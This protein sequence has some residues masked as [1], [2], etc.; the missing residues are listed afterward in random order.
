MR[1]V[2]MLFHYVW[3]HYTMAIADLVRNYLNLVDFLKNFFSIKHLIL[4][5]FAPWKKLSEEYPSGILNLGS[6]FFALIVNTLMRVVGFFIRLIFIIVG[7]VALL[8][9]LLLFILV[10]FIWILMPGILIFLLV[11]GYKLLMA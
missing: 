2:L 10:L 3:W 7:L 4:N 6:F 5:L 1:L 8:L 9:S 11:L